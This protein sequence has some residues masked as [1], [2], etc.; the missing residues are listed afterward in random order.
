MRNLR[1]HIILLVF[2]SAS[3]CKLIEEIFVDAIFH[4]NDVEK[5]ETDHGPYNLLYE[6]PDKEIELSYSQAA[7]T[8]KFQLL[9]PGNQR[10]K[11]DVSDPVIKIQ[12][13]RSFYELW[14]FK[15]NE[16]DVYDIRIRGFCNC[17]KTQS[18]LAPQV[19]LLSRQGILVH[20][21]L[22]GDFIVD[23]Q[24]PVSTSGIKGRIQET[25]QY[26]I[27]VTSDNRHFGEVLHESV[28]VVEYEVLADHE[29]TSEYTVD[30]VGKYKLRLRINP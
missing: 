17:G 15:A 24:T 29:I 7:N 27:L 21:S 30:C 16:G 25:G 26:F 28:E 11:L 4:P 19:H 22:K 2:L 14:L 12:N 6:L 9:T 5:G 1:F 18:F 3:S 8:G 20:Q 10:S 23:G 13:D